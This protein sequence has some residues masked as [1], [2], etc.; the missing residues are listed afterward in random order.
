MGSMWLIV[1]RLLVVNSK[2]V[3]YISQVA[4]ML[5]HIGGII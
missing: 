4:S 2:P 5:S 3:I 1:T